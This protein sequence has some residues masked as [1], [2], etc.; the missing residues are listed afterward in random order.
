MLNAAYRQRLGLLH[1]HIDI[2]RQQMAAKQP[3][4]AEMPERNCTAI[5][6]K[7]ILATLLA[8]SKEKEV[9]FIDLLKQRI[10]VAEVQL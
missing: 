3:P 5:F 6:E 1:A 8:E 7:G 4:K 2:S 10:T 9:S